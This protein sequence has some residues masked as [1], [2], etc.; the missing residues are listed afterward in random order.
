[1]HLFLKGFEDDEFEGLNMLKSLMLSHNRIITLG[2]SLQKLVRLEL[3]R[4]DSKPP[5][6]TRQ[7][8][9][10]GQSTRSLLGRQSF[11]L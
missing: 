3:L 9:D 11:S 7:G 4:V 5:P 6:H 2:S 8:A 1:M 10:P